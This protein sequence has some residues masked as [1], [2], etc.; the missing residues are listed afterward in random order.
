MQDFFVVHSPVLEVCR[1][2]PVAEVAR[3]L[4]VSR[5]SIY[6]WIETYQDSY[7]PKVLS[8][9]PHPGRPSVWIDQRQ[10]PPPRT[11]VLVGS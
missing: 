7:D 1:G 5:Q 11:R 3:T 10:M 2:V 9:S 4:A 8:D 6:N